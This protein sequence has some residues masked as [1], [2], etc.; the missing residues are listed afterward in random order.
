MCC[1]CAY[2]LVHLHLKSRP[3]NTRKPFCRQAYRTLRTLLRYDPSAVPLGERGYGAGS[4]A[5]DLMFA[6]L[7]HLW[8][9]QSR[10]DALLRCALAPSLSP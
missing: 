9:T 1:C 8:A 5:P 2:T 3:D 7:K 10:H 6:F 4:G